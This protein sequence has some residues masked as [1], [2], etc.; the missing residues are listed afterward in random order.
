MN[1][2]VKMKFIACSLLLV[3][4]VGCSDETIDEIVVPE[5][6]L[7]NEAQ[8]RVVRETDEDGRPVPSETGPWPVAFAAKKVYEFGVMQVGAQPE[9]IFTIENQGDAPLE[10]KTGDT[11]C[12]C[13][14]FQLSKET[15]APGE[16]AELKIRWKPKA[17]ESGFRHGGPVY[18]NDPKNDTLNFAVMGDVENAVELLPT[19]E[20]NVGEVRD[21][22]PGT[23]T[24]TLISKVHKDFE[25]LGID[26]DSPHVRTDIKPLSTEEVVDKQALSGYSIEISVLP[27]II[28]GP[29][30][31]NASIKVDCLDVEMKA[32]VLATRVGPIRVQ[33]PPGVVWIE[34]SRGMKLGS[35]PSDK[36]RKAGLIL[37]VDE[38]EL[39]GESFQ[40]LE[41]EGNPAFI[42]SKLTSLGKVEGTTA[43]YRLD[44]EI[45]PGVP[46]SLR[47]GAKAATLKLKTN[48]P[49]DPEML[50]RISYRIF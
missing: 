6:V 40:I 15:L 18:T 35:F 29:F 1:V 4:L 11:T 48:H 21:G 3:T 9:Y 50:I 13:T 14:L 45:P 10:M 2:S 37:L 25:I 24:A 8:K 5:E 19:G 17:P 30:E 46:K 36:G 44:I 47:T 32:V 16:T 31:A 12:K 7:Q 38:Q 39:D 41:S 33:P 42:Q 28:A 34:S 49:E 43:R 27:E 26:V 20:W 23:M 22:V